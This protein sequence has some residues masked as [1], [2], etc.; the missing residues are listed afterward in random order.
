MSQYTTGEIAKF[1]NVSVRT[2]QFYD[3]KGLLKPTELTE[4]GRRLYSDDDLKKL[5]LI[6]LLKSLGLAL[7]AIKD[8]LESETPHKVLLLILTEHEKEIG[9]K[10][11]SMQK[12]MKT[13]QIIKEYISSTN[14]IPVKSVDDTEQMMANN[15]KKLRKIRTVL[16]I[17]GL[18]MDAIQVYALYLWIFRGNWIPFAIGMPIVILIAILL[19]RMYHRNTAYVCSE[20]SK[21][22]QP[23]SREMFFTKHTPRT[24]KLKCPSCGYTGYCVERA[25]ET[26]F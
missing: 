14:S 22:F 8:I 16:I 18:L 23:T 17:G 20:C 25:H 11:S 13:T 4:G 7:G 26:N 21:V 9:G 6:C 12:Q 1:C 19:F 2:V 24:R 15:K 5:Q 10:I 3:T